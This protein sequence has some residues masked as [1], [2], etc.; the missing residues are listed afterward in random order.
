[1]SSALFTP[2][3]FDANPG[4]TFIISTLTLSNF[5]IIADTFPDTLRF[6]LSAAGMSRTF[7]ML[8]VSTPNTGDPFNDADYI[9]F[10]DNQFP[11]ASRDS[12]F[13]QEGNSATVELRAAIVDI[14]IIAAAV[15]GGGPIRSAAAQA[16]SLRFR[17]YGEVHGDGF[18]GQSPTPEPGSALFVVIGGLMASSFRALLRRR[19][20]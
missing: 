19:A 6:T 12:F 1:M 9:T 16:F 8:Q 5:T 20:R 4:E 7:T 14:G 13:A 15:S 17:G 11:S 3:N 18:V 10:F 2:V